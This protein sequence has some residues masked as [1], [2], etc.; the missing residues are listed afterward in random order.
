M[1]MDES[2]DKLW[3]SD[4]LG[5]GVKRIV[6]VPRSKPVVHDMDNP[7]DDDQPT[8]LEIERIVSDPKRI[9]I[10]NPTDL[11][12]RIIDSVRR[13]PNDVALRS[14][15]IDSSKPPMVR[16][17][18]DLYVAP[19]VAEALL[20]PHYV[21]D[22]EDNVDIALDAY[23]LEDRVYRDQLLSDPTIKTAHR[24]SLTD[25][26]KN[27]KEFPFYAIIRA[28]LRGDDTYDDIKKLPYGLRKNYEDGRY[29][30]N[31]KNLLVWTGDDAVERICLP[32]EHRAA[33]L[34][35]THCNLL[36]GGHK[37]STA[38]I[39]EIK[40]TFYWYGYQR[41]VKE[42]VATCTCQM[43]RDLPL[44]RVS[45]LHL[46]PAKYINEWVAIDHAG[47][48]PVTPSG[49]R[50]I[51][52]YY[53]RYSGFA[54]SIPCRSIDAFTTSTNF[55]LYWVCLFGPPDIVLSD[56]GSDFRSEMFSHLNQM[57]DITHRFTV[58]HHASTNG[59]VERHNR[60]LKMVLKVIGLKK[61]IDF[62]EG[63]SWDLYVPIA[64]AIHNNRLSRRTNYRFAPNDLFIGRRFRS[65][66]E[67]RINKDDPY[68][69]KIKGTA[70]DNFV[71]MMLEINSKSAQPLLDRYDVKRKE[72][73]DK[74]LKQ[75][76]ILNV[77]QLVKYWHGPY[78]PK[79]SA[80]LSNHWSGPYKILSSF[81]GGI[82]YLLQHCE[83][84]EIY[85]IANISKLQKFRARKQDNSN[86]IPIQSAPSEN[87][88]DSQSESKED[89]KG[90]QE[91]TDPV[92]VNENTSSINDESDQKQS[93]IS[94]D[95]SQRIDE[96]K[97]DD[98]QQIDGNRS[99]A[100]SDD[101]Q[102]IP[103]HRQTL[104][105]GQP[106]KSAFDEIDKYIQSIDIIRCCKLI[107][108]I[109]NRIRF[110]SN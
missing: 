101:I 96:G 108:M 10:S 84:S 21:E 106:T 56:N 60:V 38:C 26:I 89:P 102:S 73:F 109:N 98:D 24:F 16:L 64:N 33:L 43:A 41:D 59:A 90:S 54:R 17:D 29:R 63:G 34:Q 95:I 49:N 85:F 58:S 87:K 5:H 82:N 65:Q 13:D 32:P 1:K 77:G 37:G 78:P 27:Q 31:G 74:R 62:G 28:A 86:P 91:R 88:S 48:L 79:G 61:D 69:D 83:L 71:S 22:P 11:E 97:N 45:E 2:G 42:F 68:L 76:N 19:N 46:F 110:L 72:Q 20:D 7:D 81:N 18:D 50:Y 93:E 15:Q 12:K 57:L 36:T 104:Q 92:A 4:E 44:K 25:L 70:Y 30:L 3:V 67:W 51:T 35:Y 100:Q 52:T 103:R 9:D 6:T 107:E 47:P 99:M 80:K 105:V 55:Y 39:E 14:K 75:G 66:L 94:D 53:D 23:Y 8:P 40:Q